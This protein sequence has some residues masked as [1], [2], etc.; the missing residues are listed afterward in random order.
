VFLPKKCGQ[1]KIFALFLMLRKNLKA[2]AGK[3][4][5]N[6]KMAITEYAIAK[7]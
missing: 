4:F 6:Q 2:D 5:K 1:I 7:M 3:N